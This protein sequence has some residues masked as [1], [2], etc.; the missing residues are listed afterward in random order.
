MGNKMD[1]S[2]KK[3]DRS[4]VKSKIKR[5][6]MLI[7]SVCILI[8]ISSV[9]A[10]AR[11]EEEILK[12]LISVRTDTLNEFYSGRI[13][14]EEA[15]ERITEI[16][17]E[18]LLQEDIEKIERYFQTD[19]EQIKKYFFGDITITESEEKMI[20]ADVTI[21]WETEGAGTSE[22][23]ETTYDVICYKEDKKYKLVQ[24]F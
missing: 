5:S 7:V 3:A 13:K 22:S 21:Q 24:F 14:K 12:D 23:Y 15:I 19:I 4:K 16:E 11:S 20:C 9:F 17:D 2:K 10:A 8:G 18:Q 6:C 1:K